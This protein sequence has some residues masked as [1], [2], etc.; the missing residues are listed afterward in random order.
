MGRKT[1]P[2]DQ[3]TRTGLST[4]PI[5]S[6]RITNMFLNL[7]CFARAMGLSRI[8]NSLCMAALVGSLACVGKKDLNSSD[9]D[10]ITMVQINR[11]GGERPRILDYGGIMME[12]GYFRSHYE[13]TIGKGDTF[14][15][16]AR[17]LGARPQDLYQ[18]NRELLGDNPDAIQL[19]EGQVLKYTTPPSRGSEMWI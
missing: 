6:R 18:Q 16:V 7:A 13:A 12:T 2:P 4:E 15:D 17:Q 14:D 9:G 8:V 11:T 5:K 3:Q 19:R 1:H 10:T